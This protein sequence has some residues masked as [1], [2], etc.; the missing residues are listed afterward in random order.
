MAASAKGGML[1]VKDLSVDVIQQVID[2]TQSGIAVAANFQ[3]TQRNWLFPEI[4]KRSMPWFLV[5]RN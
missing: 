5:C 4:Q 2:A 1:A 3:C